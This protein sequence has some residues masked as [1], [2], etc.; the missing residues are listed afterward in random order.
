MTND[1]PPNMEAVASRNRLRK[2]SGLPLVE[3]QQEIERIYEFRERQDFERWMQSPLR[4][5]VERK[6]LRRIRRRINN[7]DWTPTGVLS[8]SGFAFHVALV[9]QMRR[10]RARLG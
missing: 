5:R 2:E 1:R 3:P 7:P 4:Y 10:L 6:L 9:K 8:G